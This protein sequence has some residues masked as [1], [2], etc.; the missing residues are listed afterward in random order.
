MGNELDVA[1]RRLV[2]LHRWAER[3][4]EDAAKVEE[5]IKA[6]IP[7]DLLDEREGAAVALRDTNEMLSEADAE[8]RALAAAAYQND[9]SNKR[10]HPS[11]GIKEMTTITIDE[12]VAIPWF[13]KHMPDLVSKA[14]DKT[15]AKKAVMNGL[16][17]GAAGV[18]V[19]KTPS[20]QIDAV[21]KLEDVPD[22]ATN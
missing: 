11:V 14:L 1:V 12:A 6:S 17:S 18:T 4:R 5:K 2:D 9:T 22:A 19:V 3:A 21:I 13:E 16:A 8:V 20:A 7:L 10:P 15:A